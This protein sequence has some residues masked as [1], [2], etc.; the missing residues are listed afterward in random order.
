[1]REVNERIE[2]VD[3][4]TEEGDWGHGA[5]RFEF[6]CECGGDDGGARCEAQIEMTIEEYE[7]VRSQ[8][9][10]FAV[11]PGH[12]MAALE[13]VVRRT[14]RFVIVDKKP[15]AEPLVEDDPRGAP[16]G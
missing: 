16:S 13:M 7:E 12:E 10:R 4:S 5:R 14:E 1:M 2:E 6:L 15:E 11:F 8:D 3:R 9:D